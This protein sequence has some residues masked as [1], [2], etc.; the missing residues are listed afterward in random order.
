MDYFDDEHDDGI[1]IDTICAGCDL[2][3]PVN[4][5]GL[6]DDCFA[7]LERDLIRARDWE[8]S[9]TAFTVAKD[10]REAL[11]ARIIHE[12]GA[13]YELIAAPDA[14]KPK[15]KNKRSNSSNTQRKRE[16]AA[17]ARRDYDTDD[18]LQSARDFILKSDTEWVNF[19]RLSQYL[20]E[21]FHKLK[22]KHLGKP[23]KKY[24]SLLKFLADYPSDFELRQDSEKKGLYWVRLK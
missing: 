4:D 21:T 24:K 18:V 15:R 13:K 1:L 12:Y 17:K 22:P 11:R 7:K 3:A 20:Y 14:Q 6:C 19:S 10:Q 23:G 8:Y 16:I 2:P 5:L 9:A